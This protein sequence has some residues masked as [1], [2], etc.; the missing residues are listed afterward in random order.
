MTFALAKSGAI[1]EV[2]FAE[3]GN[4]GSKGQKENLKETAVPEQGNLQISQDQQRSRTFEGRESLR[5][6]FSHEVVKESSSQH[7]NNL[8]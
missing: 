5:K 8:F 4:V 3:V 2:D 1:R 6:N 7:F